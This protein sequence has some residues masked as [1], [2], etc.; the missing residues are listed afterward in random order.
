MAWK[1]FV[2]GA[3]PIR[4][5]KVIKNR[6]G[7]TPATKTDL[8]LSLSM[9]KVIPKPLNI[10]LVLSVIGYGF[11]LWWNTTFNLKNELSI[12]FRVYVT[13]YIFYM[14]TTGVKEYRTR[15]KIWPYIKIHVENILVKLN[16]LFSEI[17]GSTSY[18]GS[19]PPTEEELNNLLIA[20]DS[21]ENPSIPDLKKRPITMRSVIWNDYLIAHHEV[22]KKSI[23]KLMRVSNY[24]DENIIVILGRLEECN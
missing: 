5:T 22:I 10:L 14:V 20:L 18:K 1:A 9:F 15:K 19:F 6:E 13:G 16:D 3:K 4:A 24:L 23:E 8:V 12:I 21:A 11:L 17:S 2:P 7:F